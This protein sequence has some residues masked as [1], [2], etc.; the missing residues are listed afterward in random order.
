MNARDMGVDAMSSV[1]ASAIGFA[2]I[3]AGMMLAFVLVYFAG[4]SARKRQARELESVELLERVKYAGYTEGFDA[5][6]SG[7]IRKAPRDWSTSSPVIRL[8]PLR[9]YGPDRPEPLDPK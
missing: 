3:A 9:P 7:A 6:Q 4:I 5:A 1:C 8:K 2:A